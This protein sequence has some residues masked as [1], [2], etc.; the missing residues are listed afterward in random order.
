[1]GETERTVSVVKSGGSRSGI[2][3]ERGSI[4]D[5]AGAFIVDG[6]SIAIGGVAGAVAG[7]ASGAAA[8]TLLGPA[9]VAVGFILGFSSG[10][11]CGSVGGKKAANKVRR[12]MGD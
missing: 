4:A 5:P 6:G 10:L 2:T 8:G 1:M 9:G 12:M 11:I 3:T 7:G